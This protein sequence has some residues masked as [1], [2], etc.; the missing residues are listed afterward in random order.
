MSKKTFSLDLGNG[1]TLEV[2]TGRLAQQTNGSALVSIGDTQVLATACMSREAQDLDFLPLSVAYQEKLY[3]A[4]LIAHSKI[5]KRENRPSDEKI[6]MARVIDRTLRPIFPKGLTHSLQTMLLIMSYDKVNEHDIVAGIA[7]SIAITISDM[8]FDGPTA[9][10]RVGL[11][12]N[13][14]VLNPTHAQRAD[15]DLD[16]I[17]SATEDAVI[18]I[19]AQANEVSEET[20]FKA[21]EFGFAAGQKI[22]R[23]IKEIAAEIGKTKMEFTPK[24]IDEQVEPILREKYE[25][26]ISETIFDESLDKLARFA[27]FDDLKDEAAELVCTRLNDP[28][29][30]EEKVTEKDVKAVFGNIIKAVIRKSILESEKRIKGRKLDEIRPLNCEVDILKRTHGSGLFNRGETQGL[31]TVT[32][33]GPEAKLYRTGI[34]GERK[35]SYF[36]HYNFPPFSVGEVS[37]RLFTGNREIGHGALAEKALLPVLPDANAFPYTIRTVTEILASNGSSSMAAVC[38]S[39]LALMAAGVPLKAP[40]AGIAM[41]LMTD[42]N[43]DNYKVLTDLQDEE[44]FGGDMDFKVA[45][46]KKGITAIQMDIKLKGIPLNVFVEAFAQA[47]TGRLEILDVIIA[48]IPEPRAQLSEFSPRL[49][50]IQIDKDMIKCLIGKGGENINGIIDKTGVNIDIADNGLVTI[51][52]SPEADLEKALAM[53][54]ASTAKPEVGK[55]YDAKVVKI[56]DFGA[57]VEILPGTQGLVHVSMMKRER[58]NHPSDVVKEGDAVKV[59]LLEIDKQGR[60]RLSMVDAL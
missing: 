29:A 54:K 57:F 6:L 55:I 5:N 48:T 7:A 41:G 13:E 22:C 45:G 33:A 24:V 15:S 44:D 8:P 27:K 49:E 26:Q 42:P 46:T 51:T 1:T 43:S 31:S 58:V 2:E 4:G 10:V 47:K 59:K 50:S 36:H 16:L 25:T 19:E 37:T 39:T 11:I 23:F 32:L 30:T 52:S 9:M 60:L 17:V 12:N 35:I 21:I 53:I 40:V 3:A 56:M 20:M 38:G 18:M 28:E 14:F 34:E